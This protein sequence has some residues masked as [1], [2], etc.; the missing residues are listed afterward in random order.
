MRELTYLPE[1]VLSIVAPSVRSPRLVT[2]IYGSLRRS[3]SGSTWYLSHAGMESGVFDGA[4]S[5]YPESPRNLWLQVC[6]GLWKAERLLRGARTGG[7]KYTKTFHNIVWRQNISKIAGATIINNLQMYGPH[8]IEY[9]RNLDIKPCFYIDGT[10]TEY[11]Y[12]YGAVEPAA[13]EG[14]AGR[15][16]IALECE[17]YQHAAK[18]F[19]ISRATAQ[20]LTSVY[21]VQARKVVMVLP[22]ANLADECVLEPSMHSGWIGD[23]FTLG[24]VGLY[25]FRKGLDKL[26]QAVGLLRQRKAPVQ[27]RIIGACPENIARMEGVEFLGRIDKYTNSARFV[28]AVRGVDLGCQLSRADLIGIAMLEFLRLGVPVL[29]TDAGGISNSLEGGGGVIV[30]CNIEAEQLALELEALMNNSA[31]YQSLRQAAVARS[32]WASWR[33]AAI[34]IGGALADCGL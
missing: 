12:T 4:F 20:N 16:A 27:L 33:R 34:E 21:G 5:L 1:I 25:P 32:N 7:F 30:P 15:R 17:S 11:L 3:F 13:I 31:C 23:E 6:G 19:T 8:F 14:D 10:L 9:Y 2:S 22:G 29:A 18:I 26:A 28:E 24:F